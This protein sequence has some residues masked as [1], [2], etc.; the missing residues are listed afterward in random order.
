M[1][2]NLGVFHELFEIV[3]LQCC[4]PGYLAWHAGGAV[5]GTV[6]DTKVLSF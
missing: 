4:E 5:D 2:S 6:N 1:Y 3:S